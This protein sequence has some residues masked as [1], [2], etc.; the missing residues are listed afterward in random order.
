MTRPYTESD[1]LA[2]VELYQLS[3]SFKTQTGLST[4]PGWNVSG[5][6]LGYLTSGSTPYQALVAAAEKV[7]WKPDWDGTT[8][9]IKPAP[10][11]AEQETWRPPHDLDRLWPQH[12]DQ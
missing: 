1:L 8:W 11:V 4:R 12:G 10:H 2:F 6:H 5:R 7:G 9:R 3:I